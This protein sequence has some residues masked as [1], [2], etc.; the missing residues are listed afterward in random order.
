VRARWLAVAV[1]ALGCASAASARGGAPVAVNLGATDATSYLRLIVLFASVSLAPALLA[2][3]TSFARIVIVLF[4]LR[5]GLS[6]QPLIPNP[7]LIGLALLLTAFSM[8][9]TLREINDRAAQPLLAGEMSLG[10]AWQAAQTPSRAF[11]TA[12]TR[13]EDLRLFEGFEPSPAPQGLPALHTLAAAYA[14]SELRAAFI[15][16]FVIYLPF[17]VIDLVVAGTVA[18]LGL[19]SLPATVLALPFKVLLFVMVDGWRLLAY[20][21]L[22]S[23]Q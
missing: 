20:A 10:A 7:V 23:L 13:A 17:V 18:S 12:H 19:V 9:G 5:A 11:L 3:V 22:S 21:L 1:V 14:I 8:S 6:S 4:F 16:G 15:I 2:V